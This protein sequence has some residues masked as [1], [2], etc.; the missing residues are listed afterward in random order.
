MA[1]RDNINEQLKIIRELSE[2]LDLPYEEF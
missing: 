2:E 1:A